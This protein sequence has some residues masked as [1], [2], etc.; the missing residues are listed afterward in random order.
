LAF[1][2]VPIKPNRPIG[3]PCISNPHVRGS[4]VATGDSRRAIEEALASGDLL[5]CFRLVRR[6]LETYDPEA[7]HVCIEDWCG[8][9]CQ[10]CS[11]A[12]AR[13]VHSDCE[14]CGQTVC[15]ECVLRCPRCGADACPQ[16][17]QRCRIC[18][19]AF[20]TGC[21]ASMSASKRLCDSC[22]IK[23]Q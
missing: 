17:V 21:V 4:Q 11:A 14:V 3:H 5:T 18:G 1:E 19:R 22:R 13:D 15:D 12:I 7:A 10:T 16:C 8:Q 23:L 6:R 2:A 9:N 20:C